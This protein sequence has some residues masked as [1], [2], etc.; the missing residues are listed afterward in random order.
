[1]DIQQILTYIS[2]HASWA[3]WIVFGALVLAGFSVPISIDL[4]LMGVALFAAT[5]APHLI[6]PLYLSFLIGCCVAAWIAYWI[7]RLMG[8]K[9]CA[10]PAVGKVVSQERL[11]IAT[12][13]FEKYGS[14]TLLAGRFI[15]FG[16]RSCI[17]WSCGLS[18]MPFLRFACYDFL[19]CALWSA[20]CFALYYHLSYKID[21]IMENFKYVAAA[22]AIGIKVCVVFFIWRKIQQRRAQRAAA[23]PTTSCDIHDQPL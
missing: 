20:I 12:H 3:P 21:L 14:W 2:E 11:E 6:L 19:A 22:I 8:Q 16:V 17:F 18:K 4:L 13:Y 23:T 1:M 7:A 5:Q 10:I 9:L 15:P